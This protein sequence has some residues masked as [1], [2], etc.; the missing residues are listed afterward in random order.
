MF[1]PLYEQYGVIRVEGTRLR[2]YKDNNNF[3]TISVGSQVS[4]AL[5]NGGYLTVYLING[6]IRRYHDYYNFINIW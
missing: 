2:I 6:Q 4:H 5:W 3:S 1:N